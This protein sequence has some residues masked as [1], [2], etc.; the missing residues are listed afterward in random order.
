MNEPSVTPKAKHIG[1]RNQKEQKKTQKNR[2]TEGYILSL[3]TNQTLKGEVAKE[4][5]TG[6]IIMRS[7]VTAAD[8]WQDFHS[9]GCM[10]QKCASIRPNKTPTSKQQHCAC[11]WILA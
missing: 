10:I 9:P 6:T 5:I 3:N 4:R 7:A 2:K 11:C 1:P 8:L